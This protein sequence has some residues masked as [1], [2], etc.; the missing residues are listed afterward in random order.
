M[1][2]KN[3]FKD[4]CPHFLHSNNFIKRNLFFF[5]EMK[6]T[7]FTYKGEYT[8]DE[9]FKKKK[10]FLK[11]KTFLKNK[12]LS[13]NFDEKKKIFNKCFFLPKKLILH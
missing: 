5:L 3:N 7:N 4:S 1:K 9:F 13:I 10:N 8:I 11:K 12:Y 6:K 2:K